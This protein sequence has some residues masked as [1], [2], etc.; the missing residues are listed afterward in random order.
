[1]PITPRLSWGAKSQSE[2]WEFLGKR[3]GFGRRYTPYRPKK[4][5]VKTVYQKYLEPKVERKFGT[6]EVKENYKGDRFIKEQKDS[7]EELD[8]EW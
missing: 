2:K 3:V 1:M 4:E 7:F 8:I 5:I 6:L